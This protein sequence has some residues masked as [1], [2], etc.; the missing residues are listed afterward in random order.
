MP[1]LLRLSA[2]RLALAINV[3]TIQQEPQVPLNPSNSDVLGLKPA[4]YPVVTPYP[5][6]NYRV[7]QKEITNRMLLKPW[8]TDSFTSAL[9]GYPNVNGSVRNFSQNTSTAPIFLLFN[10]CR[11]NI[12]VTISAQFHFLYIF[13]GRVDRIHKTTHLTILFFT[14]CLQTSKILGT[15]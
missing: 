14:F 11:E 4:Y 6:F 5:R 8:C 15:S 10:Y 13:V 12:W 9:W 7:S 3:S 2:S 1:K